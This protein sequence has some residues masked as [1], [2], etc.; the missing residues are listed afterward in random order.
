MAR[1]HSRLRHVRVDEKMICHW[2]PE[3]VVPYESLWRRFW[4]NYRAI[5]EKIAHHSDYGAHPLPCVIINAQRLS[6]SLR[7]NGKE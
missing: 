5:L 7:G 3:G 2:R 6:T 4:T 1:R